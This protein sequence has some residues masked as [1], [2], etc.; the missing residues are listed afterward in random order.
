VVYFDR[1]GIALPTGLPEDPAGGAHAGN[2]G[3]AV[4]MATG[5]QGK[6]SFVNPMCGSGTLAIEAALI[7]LDA[8]RGFSGA[9]SGSCI[10]SGSMKRSGGSFVS[11]RAYGQKVLRRADHRHGHQP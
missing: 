3:A 1:R 10:S 2:T 5:W 7:A 4:V 9:T 6:G 11:R 8:R